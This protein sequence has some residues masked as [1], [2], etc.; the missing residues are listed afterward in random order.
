MKPLRFQIIGQSWPTKGYSMPE[1]DTDENV[2]SENGTTEEVVKTEEVEDTAADAGTEDLE[3][4]KEKNKKLFERAKTAEAKLKEVKKEKPPNETTKPDSLSRD[5]AILIAQ[6]MTA[7]DLDELKV[8]A[9]AKNLPLLKAKDTPLFQGYLEKIEA[10]RKKDKAKLSASKGSQAAEET[11]DIG[12][13]TEAEH[14]ALFKETMKN[15]T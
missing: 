14:R 10:E 9:Q 15:V 13:M 4:L 2:D 5:E 3:A 6:G 11:K 12:E 7:D 1:Q 8:V